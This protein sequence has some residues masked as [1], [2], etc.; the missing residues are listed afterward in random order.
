MMQPIL[1]VGGTGTVGR[2]VTRRLLDAGRRVRVLSRGRRPAVAHVAG[3][4]D[5]EQVTG[6]V[7][8]GAGLDA[9]VAGVET[10]VQCTD[11][12]RHLADAALRAGRPHLVHLSIVGVDRVPFGYYQRKLAD[13]RLVAGSG[14]PWTILRT[15]QFHELIAL[16][17]R[18]LTKP[19][20]VVLPA[21][22][23]FQPVDAREV[24]AELARHALGAPAGRVPDLAGPEVRTVTDLAGAYLAATGRRRPMVPVRLPGRVFRAFRDGGHLAPDRAVGTITFE[25]SLAD[26]LAAGRAPYDGAIRAY[27]MPRP[28]KEAR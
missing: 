9:A 23:S 8:T 16:M 17:L 19:P 14:L 25:R 20:V 1:V 7:R 21:G 27:T 4:A 5:V 18:M 24:A 10:I 3:V 12:A 28:R 15:T 22:W 6:D 26:Q 13:E 11:P 2:A